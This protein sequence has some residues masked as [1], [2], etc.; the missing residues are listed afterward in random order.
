MSMDSKLRSSV[1]SILYADKD[2]DESELGGALSWAA[3]ARHER[4][5]VYQLYLAADPPATN[6]SQVGDDVPRGTDVAMIPAN[7]PINYHD[8]PWHRER[9][10]PGT[11]TPFSWKYLVVYTKSTLVEQT[12]PT[13][14]KIFDLR[15]NVR[16]LIFPDFD[17]DEGDLGGTVVWVAPEETSQVT[18]YY[19]WFA[20]DLSGFSTST[21]ASINPY[22]ERKWNFANCS[23]GTDSHVLPPNTPL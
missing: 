9:F 17:L 8:F 5:N 4:V 23:I 15:S 13:A 18:H 20:F 12:T 7:T 14:F 1:S 19:V 16:N 6:R 21:E 3:P 2:L 11:D 22:E 10:Y